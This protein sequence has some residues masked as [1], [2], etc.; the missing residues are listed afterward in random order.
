MIELIQEKQSVL[1]QTLDG[2]EGAGRLDILDQ[3]ERLMK[4]GAMT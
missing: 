4:K 1:D 3:L 2:E